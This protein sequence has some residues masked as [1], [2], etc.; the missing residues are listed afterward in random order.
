[1]V[2]PRVVALGFFLCSNLLMN[3]KDQGSMIESLFDFEAMK[4]GIGTATPNGDNSPFD[5]IAIPS[6][7]TLVRVQI[8]STSQESSDPRGKVKKTCYR[9][10]TSNTGNK[11]AY[12]KDDVD[13]IC[14]HIIPLN[15][16]Y[17]FPVEIIN[18]KNIRVYPNDDHR[19][20]KYKEAWHLIKNHIM[21]F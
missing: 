4:R 13:I 7:N 20:N 19:L 10:N 9:F 18:V 14:C 21:S 8:K 5:R 17:I 15:R 6:N 11:T 1:L 3:V 2:K 12:T 16:W